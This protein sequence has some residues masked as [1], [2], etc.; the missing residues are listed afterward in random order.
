MSILAPNRLTTE[1]QAK[2]EKP[3]IKDFLKVI[4]NNAYLSSNGLFT[5]IQAKIEKKIIST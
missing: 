3:E 1:I 2:I 4:Q 5:E